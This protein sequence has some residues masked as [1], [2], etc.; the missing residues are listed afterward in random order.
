ME[1][2]RIVTAKIEEGKGPEAWGISGC[3]SIFPRSLP[4]S[5]DSFHLGLKA[6]DPF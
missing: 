5:S 3:T 6:P 2:L 1:G 4:A